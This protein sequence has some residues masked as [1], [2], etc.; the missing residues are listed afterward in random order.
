MEILPVSISFKPHSPKAMNSSVLWQV[1]WLTPFGPA[2][3]PAG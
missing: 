1:F 2:F 3:P